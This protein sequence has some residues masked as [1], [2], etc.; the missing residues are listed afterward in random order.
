M[1]SLILKGAIAKT[2][3]STELCRVAHFFR[4]LMLLILVRSI[5]SS[6]VIMFDHVPWPEYQV[7]SF[8]PDCRIL[9]FTEMTY[10]VRYLTTFGYFCYVLSCIDSISLFFKNFVCIVLSEL[11]PFV[12]VVPFFICQT[13]LLCARYFG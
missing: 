2:S 9:F 7:S 11:V 1:F 4:W 8:V 13:R 5:I 10:Y 6:F 12:C 3:N